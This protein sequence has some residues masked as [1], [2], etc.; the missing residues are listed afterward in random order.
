MKRTVSS[1]FTFFYKLVLPIIVLGGI[2][3]G[4]VIF[5]VQTAQPA[6]A[7]TVVAVMVMVAV[8]LYWLTMRLKRVAMDDQYLYISNYLREI[9]V[10]RDQIVKV[11]ENR[12]INIHP[13]TV[14]FRSATEFGDRIVFMPT[15]RAFAF[16]SSHP[17]V[18]ELRS[19][20]PPA[21]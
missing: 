1:L 11:T 4:V 15:V 21:Q 9:R 16:F 14:Y 5:L 3:V 18:A 19:T 10:R 2:G 12:W 13:V 20:I 7:V 8:M 17:I 6:Q